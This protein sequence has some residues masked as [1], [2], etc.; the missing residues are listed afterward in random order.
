MTKNEIIVIL[1]KC[2]AGKDYT[3]RDLV[4]NYGYNFVISTTTRPM[5]DGDSEGDPYHFTTNADFES[6]IANGG[7]IEYREYPR[8]NGIWYYGTT[9]D[10]IKDDKPYVAVLDIVGLRAFRKRFG[11]RVR[12]IYIDVPEEE[13]IK[14]CKNRGDFNDVEWNLRKQSDDSMFTQE[15]IKEIGDTIYLCG[16]N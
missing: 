3:A 13:R 15:V 9:I 12:A 1:G 8:N 16:L 6:K 10:S 11:I 14:R 5:R 4:K 2:A 7:M